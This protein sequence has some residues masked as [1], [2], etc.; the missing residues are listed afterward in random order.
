MTFNHYSSNNSKD[1][2]SNYN[3]NKSEPTFNNALKR[4]HS[5]TSSSSNVT[6][7]QKLYSSRSSK[8]NLR[9]KSSVEQSQVSYIESA[10]FSDFSSVDISAESDKSKEKV[11]LKTVSDK[12]FY[13]Q[14]MRMK[15]F[16]SDTESDIDEKHDV[17]YATEVLDHLNLDY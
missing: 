6:L 17:L 8:T 5:K 3:S 9:L 12:M 1:Q 14:N 15:H 11:Q 2:Q 13:K 7:I 4:S 10:N 16:P